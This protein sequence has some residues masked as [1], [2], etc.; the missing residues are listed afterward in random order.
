[1]STEKA[2]YRDGMQLGQGFNTYTQETCLNDAVTVTK[3]T[4]PVTPY[5]RDYNSLL[6]E[7]YEKLATS[8][9]ISAGATV[10][11]WGQSGQVN[12]EFMSRSEVSK[13]VDIAKLAVADLLFS[14]PTQFESSDVTYLVK[15]NVEHQP[16]HDGE[17]SFNW[18]AP[19]NPNTTYGDRYISGK[20]S[21]SEEIKQS[22]KVAFT[23]Y[24]AT[25]EVTDE[26]KKAV[27]KIQKH[28]E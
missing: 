24:G 6:I 27:E 17:Y 1:M 22:A 19:E 28:S 14:P 26:V 11:G 23:M 3:P 4:P 25:G 18:V 12:V 9:D 16:T 7:E 13:I 5:T 20:W 10:S 2:P 15:V 8:L 21:E